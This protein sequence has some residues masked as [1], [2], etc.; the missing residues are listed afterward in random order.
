MVTQLT[1][2]Q[3]FLTLL[4]VQSRDGT[5]RRNHKITNGPQRM[6][7][8]TGRRCLSRS[9]KDS[10]AT[11]LAALSGDTGCNQ[12]DHSP[13]CSSLRLHWLRV[14]DRRPAARSIFV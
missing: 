6:V 14:T 12:L 4:A 2:L 9:R 11:C 7:I 8:V 5:A 3:C 1:V 13:T 10:K